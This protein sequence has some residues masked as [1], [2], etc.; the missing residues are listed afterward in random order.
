MVEKK[1]IYL[2]VS[3]HL[4]NISQVGS[5]PQVGMKKKYLKP[6]P[7]HVLFRL[8]LLV[9]YLDRFCDIV[10]AVNEYKI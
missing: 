2:G 1:G 10:E 5:F 3:T 9:G 6:P 7:C 8:Q 4:K